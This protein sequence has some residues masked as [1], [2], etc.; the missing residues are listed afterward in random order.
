MPVSSSAL[1]Q[2]YEQQ[3]S[4]L[5]AFGRYALM[6]GALQDLLTEACMRASEGLGIDHAKVLELMDGG[7]R[8]LMRAGVGWDPEVIGKVDIG[9]DALSPGGFA[10]Q[11]GTPIVSN[12]LS[13]E[14]RFETPKVLA[15]HNIKSMV[16]VIIP[17]SEGPFGL[18]EVDSSVL[19]KFTRED[20]TFLEGYANV[21]GGAI[22]RL[23]H[24]DEIKRQSVEKD[25]LMRELHHRVRNNIQV[26][27]SLVMAQTARS[28]DK[29]ARRELQAIA[30]RIEALVWFTT[31]CTAPTTSAA[32]NSTLTSK[33]SVLTSSISTEPASIMST[34]TCG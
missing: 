2:K 4:A 18:L 10:L 15:Q 16:N 7:A 28:K 22:M 12:N 9:T 11:T 6:T 25:L 19:R 20:I 30:H 23:R 33:S 29:A 8:L 34:W 26:I 17:T 31:S 13:R 21:L 5:A 3:K 24:L 14:K 27:S 32:S 1:V